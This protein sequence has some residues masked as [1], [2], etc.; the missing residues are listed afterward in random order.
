MVIKG[1]P[2]PCGF[3]FY[4]LSE[5]ATGYI[6]Y[7]TLHYTDSTTPEVQPGTKIFRTVIDALEGTGLNDG[8]TFLDQG[9][10]VCL[11]LY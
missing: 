1:K 5:A 7:A 8:I 10:V 11:L 6:H 4:L 2:I 9:Y 3:K